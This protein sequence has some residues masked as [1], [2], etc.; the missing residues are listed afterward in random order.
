LLVGSHATDAAGTEAVLPRPV[1]RAAALAVGTGDAQSVK[2]RGRR[3]SLHRVARRPPSALVLRGTP[4]RARLRAALE[5]SAY[6]LAAVPAGPFAALRASRPALAPYLDLLTRVAPTTLPVLLLGETGTGKELVARALHDASGRA[7]A[8]VA[9]N[10]ATLPEG[11]AEAEL[12]GVRRGAFTDAR[13]S[14]LGLLRRANGGTLFLDEVADLAPTVQAKLLRALQEREVRAVGDDEPQ[15]IS[16]RIVA[17]TS[18]ELGDDAGRAGFRDDLYFRLAG[19]T[20]T[21]PPLR[22]APEDLGFLVAALLERLAEEELAVAPDPTPE[23]LFDLQG[24]AFRGNVRELEHL[25]RAAAALTAGPRLEAETLRR[26]TSAREEGESA[27]TLEGHAI[28]EALR[29]AG[30][31]KSEAA[32]RLGWTRQ[33]LYRRLAALGL[34]DE[35]RRSTKTA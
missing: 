3:F 16:L 26:L 6:R 13:E 24:R 5:R 21:L 35:G 11:L 22:R 33:K 2:H 18:R 29:L 4:T 28:R 30:G 1:L 12:F 25:L 32:R 20:V 8:F 27:T 17:A 10:C 34:N 31:V 19:L 15:P 14:R 7:G 9:E 23:A